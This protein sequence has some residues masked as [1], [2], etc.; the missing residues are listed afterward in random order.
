MSIGAR[1]KLLASHLLVLLVMAGIFYFYLSGALKEYLLAETTEGVRAEAGIARLAASRVRNLAQDAPQAAA[2][3]GRE[4]RTRVTIIAADGVVVGDSE[5]PRQGLSTLENHLNRP[6]VRQAES[7]GVG[8]SIRY[9][10]TIRMPMLYVALP[11]TDAGGERGFVRLALPLAN[12]EKLGSRVRMILLA[13]VAL[14]AVVAV[15]L[16]LVLASVSSRALREMARAATRIGS[17]DTSVRIPV[18]SRDEAG[19]LAQVMNRMAGRIESQLA[20]VAGEKNRLDAILRGMGEGVIVTGND[21]VVTLVNP[22]FLSL[23]RIEGEVEGR[24]LVEISRH[25]ALHAGFR[26]VLESGAERTEEVRIDTGNEKDLLVH[27]VPLADEGGLQGIVAVFHDITDLKRLERVR[28]DFVANVSHELRTPVAVIKGYAETLLGGPGEVDAATSQR[29]LTVIHTHAERL[30]NL[31]ADLLSLSEMES[32]GARLRQAPLRIAEVVADAL[33]LLETRGAEGRLTMEIAIPP[34]VPEVLADREKILQVLINLLDNAVKY[35][36]PGGTVRV[37]AAVAGDRVT[38]SVADSGVGIP[39]ADQERI[40]ERFYRV[41]VAR[42]REQG[43]TGL[44][45]AIVKHLV[46]MHGGA[47]DV[48]ANPGG[49]SV[50]SFTL[51]RA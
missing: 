5:V 17:G 19:Y 20:A 37:T 3:I 25:P 29:F 45:L 35:T 32:G 4:S 1:G 27:W 42:S 46:Q 40:F 33:A 24:P 15:G 18:T 47:V 12:I 11:F 14:A 8:T 44:G 23:F 41:D 49:G 38:V 21:G 30:G 13:A 50:F 36:P 28:R 31:T 6:E 48:A 34:E 43:G 9:S 26:A 22:A 7:A 10:A 39:P 16:S 2:E 51:P